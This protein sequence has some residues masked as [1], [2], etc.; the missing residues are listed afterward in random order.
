MMY[1]PPSFV[2]RLVESREE[3]SA[4]SA[5]YCQENTKPVSVEKALS[6]YCLPRKHFCLALKEYPT[7]PKELSLLQK[8]ANS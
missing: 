8:Q 5:H 2:S 7:R 1:E 3:I 4:I 6:A